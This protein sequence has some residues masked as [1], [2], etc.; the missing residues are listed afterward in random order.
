VPP[1]AGR[2]VAELM[3]DA[4]FV[5]VPGEEHF[6]YAGRTDEVFERM[7]SFLQLETGPTDG[8]RRLATVLFTDI[9]G[10]TAR[11][12]ALGDAAWK[13]LLE[14]H[15]ALVRSELARA[16]GNEV[17]TAGDGFLATF[18]GPAGATRCAVA[19][20]R[21]VASLGLEIRAGVHTGEVETIDGKVGGLG[22]AIG[23]RIGALAGPS[24]VL[25]SSPVKDLTAGSGL[26]FEDAGEH[27][28]KGVPGPWR[29]FRVV[30]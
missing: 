16:G 19:V 4:T 6:P 15:H 2:A 13:G 22:V 25:V 3:P 11:S 23:A 26:R 20:A 30:A 28:L 7:R 10:S 9:V 24:Q 14:R 21:E 8:R 29:L 27:E 18:D 17:D 1:D 5:G 12:A